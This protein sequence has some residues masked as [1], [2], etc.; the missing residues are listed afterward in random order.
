DFQV[1]QLQNTAL[2]LQYQ[3]DKNEFTGIDSDIKEKIE[4]HIKQ[5]IHRTIEKYSRTTTTGNT[6][7][8]H[9]HPYM[10]LHN[11]LSLP[12]QLS[13]L[14]NK[15]IKVYGFHVYQYPTWLQQQIDRLVNESKS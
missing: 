12:F 9:H 14:G 8:S 15:H 6:S 11:T 5:Q 2:P 13:G 10:Q 4:N 1:L 3:I 7:N